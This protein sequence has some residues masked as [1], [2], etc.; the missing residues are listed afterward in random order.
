MAFDPHNAYLAGTD[1][2][3][4]NF[5]FHT[6]ERKAYIGS[7]VIETSSKPDRLLIGGLT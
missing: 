4:A 6:T 1:V 2:V 5:D 7:G 3:I